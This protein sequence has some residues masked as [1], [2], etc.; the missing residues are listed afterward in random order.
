MRSI[1]EFNILIT[2]IAT[3]F[4]HTIA[5]DVTTTWVGD[6]IKGTTATLQCSWTN[7]SP[8]SLAFSSNNDTTNTNNFYFNCVVGSNTPYSCSKG[9][10]ANLGNY[11]INFS[12]QGSVSMMISNL[13][14]ADDGTAYFC[15]VGGTFQTPN[16]SKA[17]LA[18]K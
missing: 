9:T 3:S 18:V 15:L 17:V 7:G 12:Q 2:V 4:L 11:S 14:C 6:T 8:T 16:I 1:F 5:T 13:Q 10:S